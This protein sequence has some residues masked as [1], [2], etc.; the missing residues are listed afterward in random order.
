MLDLHQGNRRRCREAVAKFAPDTLAGGPRVGRG[1]AGGSTARP[2]DVD[3]ADRGERG[4]LVP[5][6]LGSAER[7]KRKVGERRTAVAI[8]GTLDLT[9]SNVTRRGVRSAEKAGQRRP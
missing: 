3:R 8:V 4:R 5:S 6:L 1:E 7:L 2:R 9:A